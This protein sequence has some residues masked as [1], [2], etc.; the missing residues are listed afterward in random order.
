MIWFEIEIKRICRIVHESLST[1]T[2]EY[3]FGI[4]AFTQ[5]TLF[6]AQFKEFKDVKELWQ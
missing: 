5:T 4:S 2:N 1:Q 6:S 3:F